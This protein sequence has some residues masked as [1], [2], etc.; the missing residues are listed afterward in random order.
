MYRDIEALLLGS[1][2][3]DARSLGEISVPRAID[4]RMSA[5]GISSLADFA[6]LIQADRHEMDALIESLVVPETWFFRGDGAFD[7]LK[8]FACHEWTG[9]HTGKPLRILSVPCSTGEEPYSIAMALLDAGLQMDTFEIDAL[10]IS[11]LALIKA[12]HGC[13]GSNSFRGENLDFRNRYFQQTDAGY[14]LQQEIVKQVHF[15]QR[16]ILDDDFICDYSDYDVIFCRNLLIYFDECGRGKVVDLLL[17]LLNDKG[18]LFLGHADS[19][20]KLFGS[21]VSSRYPMAFAYRKRS[22]ERRSEEKVERRKTTTVLKPE[23]RAPARERRISVPATTP[24]R[25]VVTTTP[26]KNAENG[27]EAAAV[28]ANAGR[29]DE[30]ERLCQK[31]LHVYGPDAEAYF[32]LGMISNFRGEKREASHLFRKTIYLEPN[33]YQALVCLSIMMDEEGIP[34]DAEKFRQRSQRV[35][36]RQVTA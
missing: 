36:H 8:R 12:S 31:H 24:K 4:K 30:S 6:A 5:I 3:L 26:V 14:R 9:R 29:L 13:Y 17:K 21:F 20:M 19:S 2:G 25:S 15:Q 1:I 34:A 23:R 32:L 10:D 27:L 16:N 11:R 7:A 22:D 18:L 28:L 35:L 33:H